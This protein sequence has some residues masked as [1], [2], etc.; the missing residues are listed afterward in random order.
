MDGEPAM[1]AGIPV[2]AA[3]AGDNNVKFGVLPSGQ[4]ATVTHLGPFDKLV[5]RHD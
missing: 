2:G 3:V 1:E 5:D 4:Y